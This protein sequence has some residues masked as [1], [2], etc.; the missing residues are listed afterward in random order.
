[1]SLTGLFELVHSQTAYVELMESLSSGRMVH[2]VQ[3]PEAARPFLLAALWDRLGVPVLVILPRPEDARRFYESLLSYLGDEAA[4]HLFPEP[5]VLPFERLVAD[6]ATNNQRLLALSA[7]MEAGESHQ[8][9]SKDNDARPRPPLVVTSTAAAVRRT[10]EPGTFLKARHA[11]HVGDKVRLADLFSHW[12]RLGYQREGGVEVP[13]TFSHRGGIVD[14]F[15][16]ASELPARIELLGDQIDNI[17]LFDPVSQRSVRGT[18]SVSVIPAREVLPSLSDRDQVSDLIGQLNFGLCTTAATVRFQEELAAIFSGREVEELA[19]YNGFLN[20]SCILDHLPG[21]GLLVMDGEAEIESEARGLADR[22][23][24]L[25]SAR[26]SRGELPANFPSPQL[27][28]DELQVGVEQRR[29]LIVEGW[30]GGDEGFHFKPAQSYYGRPNEFAAEAHR[31]LGQ[32]SRVVVVSRHA[33]RLSEVLAEAGVVATVLDGLEH[34]PVRGGLSL[35]AGSLREGW[36]LPL[37]GG[38]LTLFTDTEVYGS[39]KQRRPRRRTSAKRGTFLSE[40]TPGGF[41]VHIDHGVAQ[42]AGTVQMD[43]SG[44]DKEYLVLEYAD[45]DKL[46]VP[47]EHLD[48]VSPYLAANEHP[49][50]PTRLGTHEWS[51]V[52]ERVKSA[53]REM[54]Q[55]LLDLFASRQ[56]AEGTSFSADSPWQREM[57]DSFPYEETGDQE[58]TIGEVKRD[59]ELPRPMDRLVCGD[60]GY[61]KTEVALRASFKTV[62]DGMQAGILVPTTVLA[63]QHYATFSERLSPFPVRVEVL[64]RFR[65][66]KEQQEVIKG[67]KD[68][69]VDIVIGTHRLLQKDVQFKNLG[70]VVVDEE[71]RFGVAHKERFKRMRKE[72]DVLTLSATPIPRTLY[73]GLSGIRDM[74]TMETPPEDRLPVKTYVSEYSDDVVKEAILRELE[75]GGQVFFL[76]NRVQTIRRVAADIKRLVPQA[77]IAVGHGQMAEGDL[78]QVMVDFSSGDVDVLVCTTIIESGLDL[79]NANTLIIDRADRF[80]LS[81]LYQLRG[82][83]GRGTHRAYSY[84]LI[85]RGRHIT[86]AA[87]KRL[88]AI[89]EASELG[90]GFRIAMR[91]L[92]IRGAGNILGAEQS[93]QIHAV[94]FELYSQLLNEAVTEIKSERGDG[95]SPATDQST[96]GQVRVSLPLSAQIQED[97]IPDLP[98]RLAVYQRLTRVQERQQVEDIREE[99]RDRFGPLPDQVENLLYLV[100]LKLLAGESEVE[101]ITQSGATVTVT[102][103]E[104]VGGARLAL[105][106][107]LGPRAKVGNQQVHLNLRGAG[108]PWQDRLVTILERLKVFREQMVSIAA[109]GEPF[110]PARI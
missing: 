76:H 70:L 40:L 19:M 28:W 14:I 84:L 1:M 81:Q 67:L 39:A 103:L 11:V 79:P 99:L 48:R 3:A 36:A 106:K 53:T 2:R 72:V 20:R 87:G 97:Y 64:S 90:S 78:E 34:P 50:T 98:T 54:A 57:E 96:R 101:S 56:V 62:S 30:D 13:G 95:A 92:E 104:A 68:G 37:E 24:E 10:L 71:Q 75:R 46:Y 9:P 43:S 7:L 94:G 16:P 85:P 86:E 49:P 77:R 5:D 23:D 74:S 4:V 8:E 45:G 6:A 105:E 22:T 35:I 89:L 15:S 93:G 66:R 63:Q 107:A 12:I 110:F 42:F 33:L 41:V 65:T 55:E 60:V 82:R 83:V 100:D 38:D 80:G 58:R 17:R 102:L 59:M 47:T 26:V 21:Q 52:K 88:K 25:R 31:T 109:V 61:G 29:R 51:R 91:D 73:L 18:D 27:T 44:D 69:T 32:G 108:D